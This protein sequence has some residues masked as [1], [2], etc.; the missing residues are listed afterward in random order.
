M[1]ISLFRGKYAFLSNFYSSPFTYKGKE[2]P[3]VEHFFQ[4]CK[5]IDEKDHEKIRLVFSPG[6]AKR[7]GRKIKLRPNWEKIKYGAMLAAVSMKFEQNEELRDKLKATGEALLTEGNTWHNN[8]WGN[9]T[10]SKCKNIIG[11]NLLGRALMQAR[12]GLK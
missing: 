12:D 2:W 6:Q 1:E 4:A 11:E 10:C 8:T 3:T 9:C 5:T 7:M